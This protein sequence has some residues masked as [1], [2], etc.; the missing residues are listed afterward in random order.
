MASTDHIDLNLDTAERPADQIKPDFAFVWKERRIVLTDPANVDYRKLLEV[1][2][3]LQFL[4]FT[5]QQEDRDFLASPEGSMEGWR[6]NLMMEGYYKHFG[7][8]K[9]R[10][11]LGF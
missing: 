11:K 4:R 10:Q 5:A 7:M 8:D 2:T 9:E 6:L 1:E 3:P